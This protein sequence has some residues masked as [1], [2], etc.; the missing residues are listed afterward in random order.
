MDALHSHTADMQRVEDSLLVARLA[1]TEKTY[2][3]A[4]LCGIAA[5]L[6]ALIF[7]GLT[8]YLLRRDLA[9]RARA[10]NALSEQKEWFSTT[11][12]SIGDAVIA[13]DQD[14]CVTFI[15]T[16]A[17]QLTGWN[18]QEALGRPL[19]EVFNIVNET[20]R[21]TPE[22]PVARVLATGAIAG[23]ANHTL[24]IS[25]DGTER[26]ID[27][28]A[29]PIRDSHGRLQGVVLV[30]RD[31]SERR[32]AEYA[33]AA[34]DRRKDEFLAMLAHELRNPLAPIRN[35]VKLLELLCPPEH[36]QMTR[37]HGI[38][39]RQVEH[40]TG[41]VDDLM[42]VSRIT[43][44]TIVLHKHHTDIREIAQ[45]ALE[46]VRPL[47][48]A[49]KHSVTMD[50]PAQSV[51]VNADEIRLTQVVT[52]LLNN[53]AKYTDEGGHI[54][55]RTESTGGE[56]VL[57]VRDDGIGIAPELL[58]HV[59]ELFTQAE[60]GA[61]RSQGGLGI[62]LTLVR[63]L[64]EM[65][66]GRV[67]ALSEGLGRGSEFVVHLPAMAPS[68]MSVAA[69][70]RDED[71]LPSANTKRILVVDDHADGADSLA[72]LL[73]LAGQEVH[74]EYDG[75]AALEMART[76]RPDVVILDIG[77]PGIDGNEVARRLRQLPETRDSV[78]IAL[79]G[80]SHEG[81]RIKGEQA[82]FDYQ[83]IKPGNIDT[84][85]EVIA[86]ARSDSG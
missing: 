26:P 66:D 50:V 5:T 9:V 83:F 46:T 3:V 59:F 30:F 71:H 17:Q 81:T 80:Y 42:D 49:H 84:L 8:A 79:T 53:A 54:V 27:D 2:R 13:T 72:S 76:L 37:M 33:L 14:A 56:A 40:L 68:R 16:I 48:E 32:R 55:M 6:L 24:L 64:V 58:P 29:A 34:A 7:I 82:G 70:R 45:H 43:R 51:W 21:Q 31:I 75:K 60:R 65:H 61:D 20:T 25:K 73:R 15:N 57:R 23:L 52:N 74:T 1:S 78:L 22:S 63:R 41:L 11:L 19:P 44:G 67:E 18:E 86:G 69:P 36:E 4:V 39:N 62:G 28:S 38:L 47:M 85:L 10:A 77:L 12:G 35:A